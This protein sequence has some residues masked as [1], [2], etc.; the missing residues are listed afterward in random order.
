[1]KP[2]F[3]A[4]PQD[5]RAWL[6]EHHDTAA[7]LWVG[8]HRKGSGRPSITWPEAV[9]EALCFGWI[10]GVR[11]RIDETRYTNRFSPRRRGSNWSAVNV[12]R[13]EELVDRGLMRP[14]GLEAFRARKADRSGVY[15]YEQRKAAALDPPDERR[16]RTNRKAWTF[17]Q[18]S[19][20]SYRQAAVWW[21]ISAK[22][23]ETRQRRLARL[24]EDSAHGRTVPPFTR[25]TKGPP[26][27]PES[28]AGR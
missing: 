2:R 5:F 20:P 3:F 26:L 13:A 7:E 11:K 1:M 8:F 19:P 6:E 18:S 27:G 22:R 12:K 10:D 15:S 28:A 21:V 24:I 14:A 16:F 9:D 25:P 4:S 17:F 23:E